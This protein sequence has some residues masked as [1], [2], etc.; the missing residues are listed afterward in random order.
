MPLPGY[1]FVCDASRLDSN[2]NAGVCI[3]VG[4]A[5]VSHLPS[6]QVPDDE[7]CCARLI[8]CG[9]VIQGVYVAP[10]VTAEQTLGV[11]ATCMPVRGTDQE[12]CLTLG[13]FNRKEHGFRDM[14]QKF[15]MNPSI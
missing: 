11:V 12:L 7:A 6:I 8:T 15:D 1:S 2:K 5:A 9:I 4:L 3:Y 14:K 10:G 13:D